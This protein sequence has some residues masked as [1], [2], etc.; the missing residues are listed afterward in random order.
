MLGSVSQIKPW[1]DLAYRRRYWILIPALVGLVGGAVVLSQM[2]KIYEAQTTITWKQQTIP[3]GY[4]PT[5]VSTGVLDRLG[6]IS[7][8]MLSRPSLEP[9]AREFKLI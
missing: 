3:Q 8:S 6:I 2:P 7:V 1:L 5:T 9:I 4:V